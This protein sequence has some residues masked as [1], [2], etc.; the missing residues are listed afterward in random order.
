MK[1]LENILII[2]SDG[3]IGSHLLQRLDS[4]NY[5]IFGTSR[6]SKSI[7]N[8]NIFY[9]NLSLDTLELPEIIFDTVIVTA[10]VT[11]TID[12]KEN[13]DYVKK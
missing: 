11:R 2:G 12:F 5:N 13:L 8:K 4:S 3:L 6:N 10:G 7:N 9:L 1:K